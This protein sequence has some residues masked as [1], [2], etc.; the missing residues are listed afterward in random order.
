MQAVPVN[1][2]DTVR[3]YMTMPCLSLIDLFLVGLA[4]DLAGAYLL[5]KGLLLSPALFNEL[6]AGESEPRAGAEEAPYRNRI[7]AEIGIVYL[8]TGFGLQVIG[9]LLEV[10]GVKTATGTSRLLA[11]IVL[12]L[13]TLAL[14]WMVW[15]ILC[16][17]RLQ[18][19]QD[20]VIADFESQA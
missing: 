1:D 10:G 5:A 11:A 6:T 15:R 2:A 13:I 12:G 19:L 17:I 4:L 14:A 9:Y 18:R 8:A 20:R 7:D 3:R 16:P